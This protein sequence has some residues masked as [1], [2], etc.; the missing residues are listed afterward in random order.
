M[1][2]DAETQARIDASVARGTRQRE[3]AQYALKDIEYV[4]S[5]LQDKA[6][7]FDVLG[8]SVLANELHTYA[9][10]LESACA[11]IR[12]VE[13]EVSHDRVRDAEQSTMNMLGALLAVTR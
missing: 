5:N 6:Y 3:K 10:R 2:I 4:M 11:D 7:A 8:Q 9:G 12:E 13:T 1:A